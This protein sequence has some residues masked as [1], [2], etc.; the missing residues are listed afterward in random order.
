M[1]AGLIDGDSE[2]DVGIVFDEMQIFARA[3]GLPGQPFATIV[4]DY[5]VEILAGLGGERADAVGQLRI[6]GESG[7]RDGYL[8]WRQELILTC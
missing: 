5:D 8:D 2:A 1:R 6:R 7:N 3:Q 4:D